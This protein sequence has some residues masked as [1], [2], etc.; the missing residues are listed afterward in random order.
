M[1]AVCPKWFLQKRLPR[2]SPGELFFLRFLDRV[3]LF[4]GRTIVKKVFQ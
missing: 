1:L 3:V 2:W 4:C